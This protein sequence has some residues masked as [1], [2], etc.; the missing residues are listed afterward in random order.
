[1]RVALG[2]LG[3]AAM[4][5]GKILVIVA[6]ALIVGFAGGF[7][8]RPFIA[9]EKVPSLASGAQT[10]AA[11]RG[12][13]YFTAHLDVARQVL[14]S[15]RDGIVRGDECNNAEAAVAKAEAQD[16]SKRFVRN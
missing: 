2:L 4:M 7:L 3:A 6:V 9:P 14:A 5:Q 16:R 8:L 10:P 13:Q 1:M 15:C 12:V 11:A